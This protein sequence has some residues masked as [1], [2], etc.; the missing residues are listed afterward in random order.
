MFEQRFP[1]QSCEQKSMR[2]KQNVSFRTYRR[3]GQ[4]LAESANQEQ[5]KS[6]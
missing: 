1:P 3:Q 6:K 5:R 4:T 2:Q